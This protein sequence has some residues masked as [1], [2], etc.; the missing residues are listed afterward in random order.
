VS[1]SVIGATLRTLEA[2]PLVLIGR[3][4]LE[5]LGMGRKAAWM[6]RHRCPLRAVRE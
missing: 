4:A 5:T 6:E 2:V 3:E 1:V